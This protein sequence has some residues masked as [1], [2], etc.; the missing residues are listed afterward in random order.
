MCSRVRIYAAVS[1]AL[2]AIDYTAAISS[3]AVVDLICLFVSNIAV[4]CL[5]GDCHLS[6]ILY[7][8][9]TLYKTGQYLSP[10]CIVLWAN[11]FICLDDWFAIWHL[12]L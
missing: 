12:V 8:S 2:V 11:T 1:S 10:V 7:S 9:S 5:L 6:C 3:A 4:M